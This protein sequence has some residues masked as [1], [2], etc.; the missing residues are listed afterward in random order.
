MKNLILV[1]ILTL[2]GGYGV[3]VYAEFL[4]QV[5]MVERL[6]EAYEIGYVTGLKSCE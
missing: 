4:A 3:M 5:N 6:S 1:V 2:L